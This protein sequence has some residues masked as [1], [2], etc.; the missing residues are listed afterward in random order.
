MKA[1]EKQSSAAFFSERVLYLF[2]RGIDP[3]P[4]L[5]KVQNRQNYVY[6][7][8]KDLFSRACTSTFF[9]SNDLKVLIDIL[10]RQLE[11]FEQSEE[12][13]FE[14]LDILY[15]VLYVTEY[16]KYLYRQPDLK[17]VLGYLSQEEDNGDVAV[18]AFKMLAGRLRE[19]FCSD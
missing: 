5:Y 9:Y 19:V 16:S 6:K 1:L 2:N 4:N 15:R 17:R 12:S 11:N 3:V 18:A 7:F 8:I 14:S 13:R 10:M